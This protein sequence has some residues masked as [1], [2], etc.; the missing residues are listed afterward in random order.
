[1]NEWNTT[2]KTQKKEIKFS[3]N[4]FGHKHARTH[5]N[6]ANERKKTNDKIYKVNESS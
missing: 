6:D 4:N 5:T 3:H 2:T 1:M